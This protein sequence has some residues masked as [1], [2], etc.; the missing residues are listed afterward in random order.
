M[1]LKYLKLLQIAKLRA[2]NLETNSFGIE[3]QNMDDSDRLIIN[4]PKHSWYPRTPNI[5]RGNISTNEDELIVRLY[6][7]LGDR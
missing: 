2:R 1:V 7:L 6:H 4:Q 5:K 3:G